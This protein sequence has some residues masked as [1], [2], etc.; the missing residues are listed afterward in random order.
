[1]LY[2][3][4]FII[5]A[6]LITSSFDEESSA[7]PPYTDFQSSDASGALKIYIRNFEN[8]VKCNDVKVA[9]GQY[10]LCKNQELPEYDFFIKRQIDSGDWYIDLDRVYDY[11]PQIRV[12]A[13]NRNKTWLKEESERSHSY[14]ESLRSVRNQDGY[15]YKHSESRSNFVIFRIANDSLPIIEDSTEY[16]FNYEWE[17]YIKGYYQSF[18]T[19]GEKSFRHRYKVN[20]FVFNSKS[21]Y[22]LSSDYS[23]DVKVEGKIERYYENGNKYKV[24]QYKDVLAVDKDQQKDSSEIKKYKREAN[25][26][27]YYINRKL[28]AE[29]TYEDGIRHG[30]WILYYSNGRIAEKLSYEK[31]KKKGDFKKFS[32]RGT[33]I[34]K[35]EYP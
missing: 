19:N 23:V 18:Y 35:G 34:E 22:N 9:N 13:G 24:I 2:R 5:A 33:L 10:S 27:I 30:K 7:Y 25:V 26:K 1:M 6:I 17:E 11:F 14:R 12:N 21:K 16:Q 28:Q 3:I 4:L 8:K 32:D 20:R 31:G 15:E 29:G